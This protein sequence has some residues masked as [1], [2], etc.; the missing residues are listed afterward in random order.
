[1]NNQTEG[2]LL[3]GF[4]L[5]PFCTVKTVA[6]LIETETSEKQRKEMNG[7]LVDPLLVNARENLDMRLSFECMDT[8]EL[9]TI[10]LDDLKDGLSFMS[11]TGQRFEDGLSYS[12]KYFVLLIKIPKVLKV[13]LS[14]ATRE[15]LLQEAVDAL[16]DNGICRQS[17]SV[18]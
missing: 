7:G 18:N 9:L 3:H 8:D 12:W 17:L 14:T 2:S 1:M 10:T 16:L 6:N 4:K 11:F 15:K 13:E 5:H